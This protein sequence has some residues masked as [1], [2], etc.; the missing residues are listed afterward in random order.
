[1][2]FIR[3]LGVFENC[4][5]FSVLDGKFVVLFGDFNIE[6]LI[7]VDLFLSLSKS[8]LK[9]LRLLSV[10]ILS[11]GASVTNIDN[12]YVD[13]LDHVLDFLL[14]LSGNS[15]ESCLFTH[16]FFKCDSLCFSVKLSPEQIVV[17]VL[18]VLIVL[19]TDLFGVQRS[20]LDIVLSFSPEVPGV[21]N[22]L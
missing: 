10:L 17:Y 22:K 6:L 8:L 3:L 12:L 15:Y 16:D 13:F 18:D 5:L 1:M 2:V 21:T 9:I 4:P 19:V 11:S 14:I 7:F 20:L